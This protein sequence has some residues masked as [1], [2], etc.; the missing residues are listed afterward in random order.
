MDHILKLES[1]RRGSYDARRIDA[2]A[3]VR[4]LQR[5]LAGLRV[6]SA[7]PAPPASAL[8][9][10]IMR[11]AVA[12]LCCEAALDVIAVAKRKVTPTDEV[13]ATVNDLFDRRR[14]AGEK[15]YVRF[16]ADVSAADAACCRW[17]RLTCACLQIYRKD[18]QCMAPLVN[19]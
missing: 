8:Q 12:A 4:A 19:V 11:E 9:E 1:S 10:S 5:E 15:L 18:Y 16:N 17:L 3:E 14:R 13:L 2:D 6:A 7:S